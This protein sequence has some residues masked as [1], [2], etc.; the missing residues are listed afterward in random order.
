GRIVDNTEERRFTVHHRYGNS[1][2]RQSWVVAELL[3]NSSLHSR[4]IRPSRCRTTRRWRGRRR[5]T[6][7]DHGWLRSGCGLLNDHRWLLLRVV[8]NQ[9]LRWLLGSR[10]GVLRLFLFIYQQQE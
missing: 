2:S 9:R 6:V 3:I 1:Q 7:N 4:I 8:L 10:V 5:L